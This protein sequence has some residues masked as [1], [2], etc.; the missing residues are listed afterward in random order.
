M[1]LVTYVD[2]YIP[3]FY[4]YYV[5]IRIICIVSLLRVV[6]IVCVYKRYIFTTVC[7]YRYMKN[8]QNSRVS[9]AIYALQS[10]I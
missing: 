5:Y 3:P 1:K 10:I 4:V 2:I 7:V 6:G 9:R 8:V